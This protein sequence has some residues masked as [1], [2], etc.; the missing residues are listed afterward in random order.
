M[1]IGARL[2]ITRQLSELS[3]NDIC[4]AFAVSIN[5]ITRW[6][7]GTRDLETVFLLKFALA[8]GVTTDWILLGDVT[9]LKEPLR[10]Q[11]LRD[12]RALVRQRPAPPPANVGHA[13]CASDG[14]RAALPAPAAAPD[15]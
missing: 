1:E 13:P 5:Q 11:I 10:Q 7:L 4:L 14:Q 15:R 6:E 2:R 9:H 3:R 12:H 8:V